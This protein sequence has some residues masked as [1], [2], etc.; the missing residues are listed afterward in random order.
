M[1]NRLKENNIGVFLIYIDEAHSSA[2]PMYID[3]ILNVEQPK[4]QNKIQDRIKRA[5]YF[6][7]EYKPPYKIYVDTW[8]NE[9]AETYKAWPDKYYIID[10]NLTIIAKSEYNNHNEGKNDDAKIIEDCT[11]ALGRLID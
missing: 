2:W 9:F 8:K 3:E 5:K 4:P 6:I 11:V 10:E 1:A 7:N